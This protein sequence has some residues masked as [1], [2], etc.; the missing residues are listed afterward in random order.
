M[1][2]YG[3]RS[4]GGKKKYDGAGIIP[5]EDEAQEGFLWKLEQKPG[6]VECFYIVNGSL[7]VSSLQPVIN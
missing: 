3:K 7:L 6:I 5:R 1:K 2:V 4:D